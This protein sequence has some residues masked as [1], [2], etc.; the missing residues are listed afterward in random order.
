MP[1]TPGHDAYSINLNHRPDA[2]QPVD[3][4]TRYTGFAFE[5]IVRFQGAYY[6]VA[7]DGLYQLGGTTDAGAD[8]ECTVKTCVDDFKA[9]EK[10]TVVSAFLAGR[11]G[12]DATIT[13]H[14]GE[15]GEEA[16]DFSTPRGQDAQNHRQKFGRGIK[17]R[18]FAIGIV[19]A[20]ALSIDSLD[21]EVNKLSRRI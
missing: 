19:T 9:P 6:G 7:A 21:L 20:G 5:R 10:K 12:P 18:Y 16:Y 15:E 13:L 3:E 14:A 8:I 11:L 2:P 1:T 17:H 4:V